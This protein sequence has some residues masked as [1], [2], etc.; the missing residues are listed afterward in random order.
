MWNVDKFKVKTF[1]GGCLIS[2]QQIED[3][4]R[5]AVY[6]LYPEGILNENNF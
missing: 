3:F 4:S 6:T 2:Y 5:L 1:I